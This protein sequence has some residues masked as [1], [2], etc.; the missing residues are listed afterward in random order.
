MSGEPPAGATDY[1]ASLSV[2]IAAALTRLTFDADS[3]PVRRLQ[4]NIRKVAW[5]QYWIY[6]E[7]GRG[8]H[9]QFGEREFTTLPGDIM[10]ADA[11]TPFHTLATHSYHHDLWMIPRGV[12]DRHLPPL[13][14]PLVIHFPASAGLASL[15]VAYL[16]ALSHLDDL[17]DGMSA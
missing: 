17:P 8:A 13:P 6:R 14:R 10:I 7:I 12:L 2:S 11:D 3:S 16:D 5:D 15:L 9:I 1:R 4:T